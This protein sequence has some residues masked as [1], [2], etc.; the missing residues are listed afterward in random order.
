MKF[1]GR[2][3]HMLWRQMSSRGRGRK[4]KKKRQEGKRGERWQGTEREEVTP[5]GA[6]GRGS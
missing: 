5:H 2:H 6:R 3:K 1:G 4:E